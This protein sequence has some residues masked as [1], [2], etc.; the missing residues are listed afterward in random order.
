MEDEP[1]RQLTVV[2]KKGRVQAQEA[3]RLRWVVPVVLQ[4][5]QP[6]LPAQRG[7]P[8]V[9]REHW[10]ATQAQPETATVLERQH[11]QE[12][13]ERPELLVLIQATASCRFRSECATARLCSTM[14]RSR[15]GARMYA[16]R[17]A[18]GTLAI[19]PPCLARWGSIYPQSILERVAP[20][21]VLRRR[22]IGIVL[23]STTVWSSVGARP[24]VSSDLGPPRT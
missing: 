15:A 1:F 6:M 22:M 20:Y 11:V 19:E 10:A 17:L 12:R 18:W 24:P 21:A 8:A 3:E 9:V 2:G 16:A 5:E 4:R 23:G 7:K 14:A 13:V